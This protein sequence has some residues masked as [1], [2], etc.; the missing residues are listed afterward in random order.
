MTRQDAFILS[1]RTVVSYRLRAILILLAM[2]LGVAAVVVLTALGEGARRFVMNQFAAL[3]TNLIIIIPGRSETAGGFIGALV[4]ET[5]RDLTLDDAASLTTLPGVRR[6]APLNVG[7]SEISAGGLLREV[8]LAGSTSSLIAIRGMRLAQGSFTADN[9]PNPAE[10]VL[11]AKIAHALFPTGN[12]LGQR[13]RLGDRRF[14]VAGI[15]ALQGESMGINTDEL[16]LI[17]IDHAQALFNTQSLFRI[18]VEAESRSAIEPAKKAIRAALKLRHD[19][20]EDVTIIGQDAILA[21]FDK[22]LRALTLAVSGIAAI[23]LAVA[24]ILVMNVMLV[25]VSQRTAE[26][27]LLKAIGATHTDIRNLFLLETLWLAVAGAIAGIILGYLGSLGLRLAYPQLP[28]YPPIWASLAAIATA[29]ITG[30]AASILPAGKAARLN[31]VLAL[32]RR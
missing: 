32:S 7:L 28:A 11:G 1:F 29:L 27:G 26:I 19:D 14:R 9:G 4:G 23:S 31:P 5:P 16:V 10:A 12:A 24:G 17:P 3:G 25:A 30:I 20:E 8:P 18:M 13:I 2:A 22:V 15:F 21:T 6:F